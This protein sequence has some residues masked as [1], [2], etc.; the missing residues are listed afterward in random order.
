MEPVGALKELF[1]RTIA[2]IPAAVKS[3]L[4]AS[5]TQ[6]ISRKVRLLVLARVLTARRPY[7][8]PEV[9]LPVIPVDKLA[10]KN[11]LARAFA[12]LVIVASVAITYN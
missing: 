7:E 12:L 2:P 8:I 9:S 5:S 4:R 10:F 11:T 6:P 1:N 3:S